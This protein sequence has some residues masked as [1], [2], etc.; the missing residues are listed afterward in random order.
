MVGT[1]DGVETDGF[2]LVTSDKG[3]QSL[4]YAWVARISHN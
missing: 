3:V 2:K 4:R 1:L